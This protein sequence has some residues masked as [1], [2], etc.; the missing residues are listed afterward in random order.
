M[1]F[2]R[3]I[4]VSTLVIAMAGCAAQR[5]QAQGGFEYAEIEERGALLIPEG[6]NQ[7]PQNPDFSIPTLDNYQGPV[8]TAQSIRSPRQVMPLVPGSRAEDGSREARIWFDAIEDMNDVAGWVW[9]ELQDLLASRD[10]QVV[11]QAEQ[12]FIETEVIE[13]LEGTRSRG[14]FWAGLTGDRIEMTSRYNLR[15]DMQAPS[16]GRTAQLEVQASNV[17]YLVDGTPQQLPVN[18]QREIEAGFLNDLSMQMQQ[19]FERQRV[20]QV[21]ATRAL[22]HAESPQGEPA[23]ALDVNFEAGWVL[24]PGV[25]DYLGFEVEDLNQREGVY[26]ANYQPGGRRGFFSRLAFWSSDDRGELG[27][28]RGD[29]YQFQVDEVDGVFYIVI[30]RDGEVL[31]DQTMENLFPVFAEA[32]SEHAD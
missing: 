15:I 19:N 20:A 24:I 3:G 7:V 12:E 16:H 1:K 9:Q 30:S 8:G 21:R 4:A 31:D 26:Y 25:L 32:F 6:M 23:Y 11:A 10:I 17:E 2:W 5:D 13:Q 29:G 14:G 27:L 18:L 22:R 28:P